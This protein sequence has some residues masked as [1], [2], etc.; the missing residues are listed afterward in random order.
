VAANAHQVQQI[1]CWMQWTHELLQQ[2]LN[3]K[4]H[5]FIMATIMPIRNQLNVHGN[6]Q[7]SNAMNYLLDTIAT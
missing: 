5:Y 4:Q 1:V 7:T 3:F 6:K 2:R